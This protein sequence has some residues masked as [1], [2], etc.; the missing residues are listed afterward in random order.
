MDR[1]PSAHGV[2]GLSKDEESAPLIL[3][4]DGEF[5]GPVA[6]AVAPPHGVPPLPGL[7]RDIL[8]PLGGRVRGPLRARFAGLF[9]R[10]RELRHVA[11]EEERPRARAQGSAGGRV[12]LRRAPPPT[13][14]GGRG[15]AARPGVPAE[16]HAR[17]TSGVAVE[18]MRPALSGQLRLRRLAGTVALGVRRGGHPRRRVG[19]VPGVR[20]Q[21]F[22]GHVGVCLHLLSPAPARDGRPDERLVDPEVVRLGRPRGPERDTDARALDLAGRPVVRGQ[23]QDGELDG[24]GLPRDIQAG[25]PSSPRGVHRQ[26]LR[27]AVREAP[28]VR[29]DAAPLRRP[30][31]GAVPPLD[32]GGT[33]NRPLQG[34][35]G[36]RVS[37]IHLQGRADPGRRRVGAE[38]HVP[39][40]VRQD[41]GHGRRARGPGAVQHTRGTA[42][43]LKG[44]VDHGRRLGEPECQPSSPALA[45]SLTVHY[46]QCVYDAYKVRIDAKIA[47]I[48][49]RGKPCSEQTTLAYAGEFGYEIQ[50]HRGP[51]RLPNGNLIGNDPHVPELPKTNWKMPPFPSFFGEK[52]RYDLRG[53]VPGPSNKPI[54]VVFNKYTLEWGNIPVNY[55]D[56]ESLRGLLNILSPVYQVVY[57]RLESKKLG[58]SGEGDLQDFKDKDVI[59][60]EYPST[61]LIDDL[62]NE[63]TMDYNLLLFGVASQADLFVSV[64]GG[65]CVIASL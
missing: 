57:V 18:G 41:G 25:G 33:A 7:G 19:P 1:P 59:R 11:P 37:G 5:S 47:S 52:G 21:R 30:G 63:A 31:R 40:Q 34:D 43:C 3:S 54:A 6:V 44:H 28:H 46:M 8:R 26:V 16:G 39:G 48:R 42:D 12:V 45:D 38:S 23:E 53:M 14:G 20:E 55:L 9:G 50:G 61:I 49:D 32:T 24:R 22:G 36:V 4:A 15:R 29:R 27:C 35:E 17:Q 58:D 60:Q 2:H 65:N 51:L 56:I 64:L 10:G 62:Y 13:G